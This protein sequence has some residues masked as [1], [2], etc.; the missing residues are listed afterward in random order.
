MAFTPTKTGHAGDRPVTDPRRGGLRGFTLV[1]LLVVIAIIAVLI[2]ILLPALNAARASAIAVQCSSNLK[3]IGQAF[4]L[5]NSEFGASYPPQLYN[6][7]KPTTAPDPLVVNGWLTTTTSVG[8]AYNNWQQLIWNYAGKTTKVFVCPA[9]EATPLEDFRASDDRTL[10]NQDDSSQ[11]ACVLWWFN[12]GANQ[13]CLPSN[14][15]VK[16][17]RNAAVTMLA[18]D[19]AGYQVAFA[20][21]ALDKGGYY[22]PGAKVGWQVRTAQDPMLGG[23]QDDADNGR[24][25]NR[26]LNV[27]YFD[28]H[29]APLYAPDVVDV[30]S[31]VGKITNVF[32]TGKTPGD[33]AGFAG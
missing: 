4:S 2:S 10:D 7:G 12:Y 19:Y 13:H 23:A 29:V 6:W 15:F 21:T 17:F 1:E 22:M 25:R 31:A 27:L 3:Q 18:M 26:T 5:Y 20:N 33:P 28:G 11:N 16:K 32:W 8:G 24:H 14:T 30:N 9:H